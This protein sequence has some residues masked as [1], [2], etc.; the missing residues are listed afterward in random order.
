VQ[1]APGAE[2]LTATPVLRLAFDGTVLD[3]VARRDLTSQHQLVDVGPEP[4]YDHQPFG[5]IPFWAVSAAAL[6][7]VIVDRLLPAGAPRF[8]VTKLG[9]SG[10]TL[11]SRE[12]PFER[13][14]L[15]TAVVDTYVVRRAADFVRV[16]YATQRPA[17]AAI[18]AGLFIS[19]HLPAASDAYVARD[20]TVWIELRDEDPVTATWLSL[21]SDGS[22]SGLADLPERFTLLYA[23]ETE[24]WGKDFDALDV[25]YN[26]RDVS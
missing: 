15:E 17:E 16:G 20:G 5:D 23:K 8:R 2:T 24:L 12:Y 26:S 11:W 6:A 4:T 25:P 1:S 18:R 14:S 10:D 19:E 13:M 21:S 22:V 9:L 3:T 7:L